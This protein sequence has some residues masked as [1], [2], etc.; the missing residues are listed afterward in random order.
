[1]KVK[2][3]SGKALKSLALEHVNKGSNK[4]LVNSLH[5]V[6]LLNN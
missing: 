1:M 4:K 6:E 2:A 3:L 5:L